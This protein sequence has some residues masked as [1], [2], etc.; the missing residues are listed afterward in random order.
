M[1]VV[2]TDLASIKAAS[3]ELQSTNFS[4]FQCGAFESS[5]ER[6]DMEWSF[7]ERDAAG[8]DLTDVEFPKMAKK[9]LGFV[10]RNKSHLKMHQLGNGILACGNDGTFQ[11]AEID[12]K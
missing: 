8:V 4:A 12:S 7:A 3:I 11:F 2:C 6:I 5:V 9:E 1:H 10:L